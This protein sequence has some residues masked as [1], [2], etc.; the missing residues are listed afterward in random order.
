[1]SKYELGFFQRS[2]I[3][4]K[5]MNLSKRINGMQDLKLSF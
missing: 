4:L 1:M 5:E 3:Q 2:T